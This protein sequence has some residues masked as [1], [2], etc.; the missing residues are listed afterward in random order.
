MAARVQTELYGQI[1][2][3]VQQDL[4]PVLRR[5]IEAELW[6]EFEQELARRAEQGSDSSDE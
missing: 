4:E 3:Q 5:Q 6:Q 2:E 1:A